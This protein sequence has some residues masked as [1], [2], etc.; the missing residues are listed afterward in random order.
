M[1][2]RDSLEVVAKSVE[3]ATEIGLKELDA[4]RNE[5]EVEVL[6]R[7]RPG[8][9]GFGSDPARVRVSRLGSSVAAARATMREDEEGSDAVDDAEVTSVGQSIVNEL[10]KH[11]KVTAQVYLQDAPEGPVLE[12]EGED[13]GLLIG[14]RGETLQS[15]EYLVNFLLSRR[16]E[17]RAR[18]QI[19]VE[20]YKERRYRSLRQIAQRTAERVS[21]SGRPQG[22]NPMT[23]A[24]RRVVHMA[25]ANNARV[26]T[27]SVGEG[28]DRKVIVN[29][30]GRD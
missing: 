17:R 26:T 16:L 1:E 28:P 5:V 7:G 29:P 13:S 8:F 27:E 3:E 14:R 23:P 25:L 12:I 4:E 10:L 24:E 30:R 9:L 15:L 20:G 22:L 6:S 19:D 2:T 18:I 11:M 21:R